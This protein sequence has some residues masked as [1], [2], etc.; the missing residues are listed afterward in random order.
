M[1]SHFKE[2]LD[3]SSLEDVPVDT[4]I[5]NLNPDNP[6]ERIAYRR[7]TQTTTNKSFVRAEKNT[8]AQLSEEREKQENDNP[9]IGFK[10]TRYEVTES[11]G[12]VKITIAKRI[13]KEMTFYVRTLDGSAKSP[14]DYKEKFEL[15]TMRDNEAERTI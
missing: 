5:D 13:S 15:F 10:H 2:V 1:Q 8:K 4:L 9:H 3:V 14:E 12:H 11:S 6:L 7:K